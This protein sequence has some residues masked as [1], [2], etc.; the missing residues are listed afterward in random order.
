MEL[1]TDPPS[2]LELVRRIAGGDGHA[3]GCLAT[4]LAPTLRRVLFRLGLTED[5]VEDTLQ[6][7][8]IRVWRGAAGFRG[9]AAVSTWAC[10]IALNEA[11]ALLRSQKR[12]TTGELKPGPDPE[13]V[14]ERRQQADLVRRAVMALPVHLR[15]VVILREFEDLPYRTI[16]ELLEIPVGTVMS[17]LSK[18]RW[19][20]RRQLAGLEG[21]HQ[22]PTARPGQAWS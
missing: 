12:T 2:D 4:R 6:E 18:A 16:A 8:L 9:S 19:Q 1:A 14:L 22:V 17:R 13:E 20:L 11:I 7:T 21:C 15:A 10:R 3:F 5:E